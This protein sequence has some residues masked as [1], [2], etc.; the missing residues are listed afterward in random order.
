[1][2]KKRF[3]AVVT[4]RAPLASQ[5]NRPRSDVQIIMRDNQILR[6]ELVPIEE[7]P[8]GTPALIHIR[9][10][11]NEQYFLCS[12][13]PFR[14]QCAELLP[15]C[16]CIEPMRQSID[17]HKAHIMFRMCIFRPGIP[18]A[19]N[20]LH[21]I[22]PNFFGIVAAKRCSLLSRFYRTKCT[23]SKERKR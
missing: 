11:F 21:R 16:A 2:G 6:R 20:D 1:M 3:D 15:P 19:D 12:D 9:Q 18:K 22:P 14:R 8:D 4:T 5:A 23:L 13:A 7:R 17:K 10:R